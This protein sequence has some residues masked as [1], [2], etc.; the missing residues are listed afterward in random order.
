M[1]CGLG[2]TRVHGFIAPVWE[3]RIRESIFSLRLY[4]VVL[5]LSAKELLVMCF[6]QTAISGDDAHNI[7]P[8]SAGEK[9][10]DGR[11]VRVVCT[12]VKSCDAGVGAKKS[13]EEEGSISSQR[14][15]Q[16]GVGEGDGVVEEVLDKLR[17]GESVHL[18]GPSGSG[19]TRTVRDVVMKLSS[20]HVRVGFCPENAVEVLHSGNVSEALE[21][22][23]AALEEYPVAVAL[24]LER[25]GDRPL[26]ELSHGERQKVALAR[27]LSPDAETA[28]LDEPGRHLD[29]QGRR[30]AAEALKIWARACPHGERG[31]LVAETRA[32]MKSSLF[33][34]EK[35]FSADEGENVTRC[36]GCGMRE[37]EME[38][39][40][41]VLAEL[42]G[43]R[44]TTQ[45]SFAC[46]ETKSTESHR[47][48]GGENKWRNSIHLELRL[49]GLVCRLPNGALPL[50]YTFMPGCVYEIEGGMGSGKTTLLRTLAGLMKPA[51][52]GYELIRKKKREQIK[53]NNKKQAGEGH[54]AGVTGAAGVAEVAGGNGEDVD[55]LYSSD[56]P[57][58]FWRLVDKLRGRGRGAGSAEKKVDGLVGYVGSEPSLGLFESTVERELSMGADP[59]V[60]VQTALD[61]FGAC[62]GRPGCDLAEENPM[63][64]NRAEKTFLALCTMLVKRP[65]ILLLDEPTS[66][67]D[68]NGLERLGDVLFPLSRW[69]LVLVVTHDPVLK[70]FMHTGINLDSVEANVGE[71]VHGSG[72]SRVDLGGLGEERE[73]M[74]GAE[75]VEC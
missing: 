21:R 12:E 37:G 19:K 66:G 60:C 52:G 30:E 9:K 47:G 33:T 8:D 5:C 38:S 62:V 64:L 29:A 57:N 13:V 1:N 58:L 31:V 26:K 36:A 75:A 40:E 39:V 15:G 6:L 55:L 24:G 22:R 50:T 59:E 23:D 32:H 44:D 17:R 34:H 74:Q 43:R 46:E 18:L 48:S 63:N 45:R 54:L 69:C 7:G 65:H 10:K 72:S 56:R 4:C 67:L 51:E 68:V 20:S 2:G 70:E 16:D 27:A 53:G 73:K 25:F 35:F 28:V 11:A 42:F 71:G 14:A 49:K 3:N 61:F 41:S